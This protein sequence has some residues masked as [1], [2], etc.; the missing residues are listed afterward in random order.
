MF[1]EELAH[2]IEVIK[3]VSIELI[4]VS[5]YYPVNQ[6]GIRSEVSLAQKPLELTDWDPPEATSP[7]SGMGYQLC[8]ELALLLSLFLATASLL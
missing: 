5:P 1:F 3:F 4:I 6:C 2:F 7:K 8:S